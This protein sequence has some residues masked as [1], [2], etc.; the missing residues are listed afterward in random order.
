MR[1][2]CTNYDILK[3]TGFLRKISRNLETHPQILKAV[4]L[5]IV[6]L[7]APCFFWIYLWKIIKDTQ[8]PSNLQQ[9]QR[10]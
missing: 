4:D 1:E 10:F 2:T 7:F 8:V 5:E 9:R 3:S 6:V